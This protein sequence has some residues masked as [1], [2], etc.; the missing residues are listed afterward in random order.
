MERKRAKTR[1]DLTAAA[2]ALIAEH[3]VDGLRVSDVTDRTD[4]ALGSFY[5]HFETKEAVV[6]AVVESTITTVA[7][8]VA[9]AAQALDDP[10]EALS[11]GVRRLVGLCST[12]PDLARLLVNLDRAET[13]FEHLI[14]PQ[15]FPIMERGVASGR[16]S[17][18]DPT[19]ALTV[20]IAGVLATIRGVTEGRFGPDADA[21]CA[22]ALLRSVG[23]GRAEAGEIA[24]RP[25][26]QLP[27]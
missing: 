2:R 19:L 24:H 12:D 25:L 1:E 17:V 23:L 15:A 26:P 6:E 20:A 11:V 27:E 4:V 5:S 22:V 3:G 21:G 10:A 14:W 13:R 9:E 16:F 8:A 18:D 7:A